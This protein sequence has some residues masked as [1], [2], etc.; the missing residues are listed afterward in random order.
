[1]GEYTLTFRDYDRELSRVTFPI[2]DLVEANITAQLALDATLRTAVAGIT[3]GNIIRLTTVAVVAPQEDIPATDQN[4]QRERKWLVLYHDD[5]TFVKGRVTI[6]CANAELL[7]G[8]SA[9]LVT[10]SGAGQ[11]FKNAFVAAVP[12][13]SGNASVV[14]RVILV[15]RNT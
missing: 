6:P 11:T 3:L 2:P 13:P 5:Q 8:N 9:E 10:S 1:M 15:G 14:D 12:G 4:A 7:T